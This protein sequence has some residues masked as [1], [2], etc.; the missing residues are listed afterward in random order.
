MLTKTTLLA[1]AAAATLSA[2]PTAQ[3]IG[4]DNLSNGQC[5]QQ[6]DL[7]VPQ[8]NDISLPGLGV[9]YDQCN[10][11]QQTCLGDVALSTPAQQV[12]G[13]YTT[14]IKVAD[15]SGNALLG[16]QGLLD[17]TR[18]WREAT[19]NGQTFQV[20]RFT[21][22]ADLSI[23]S[24][25]AINVCPVPSCLVAHPTA[26][27]Y[28][29]VDYALDCSNPGGGLFENAVVMYH[30][31]DE[32]IHRPGLSDRPGAFHPGR[33]FAI[34]APHTTANPFDPTALVPAPGGPTT[35]EAVR[36]TPALTGT[37]LC[38]TEEPIVQGQQLPLVSGC[39]CPLSVASQQ[40]TAVRMNGIGACGAAGAAGSAYQTLNFFPN[41]PWFD[42]VSTSLGRWTT[43]ASYPGAERVWVNEGL[44]LYD[45]SCLNAQGIPGT[46]LDMNYGSTTGSG[47][48]PFPT[49][50]NQAGITD[51]FT[52]LASNASYDL[53][54]PIT[55]PILGTMRKS[56]HLIYTNTP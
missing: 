15:C 37:A 3:C 12:C 52:D 14:D 11:T 51:R 8:W 53:T 32:F 43:M 30:A 29:Y 45:D 21:L 19:P 4:P 24:P 31:C 40:Q 54:Q 5:W 36:S 48:M 26:F 49:E 47:Y 28:G 27:F 20:W 13:M 39:L 22:K 9:C 41:L 56:T 6:V 10:P 38:I 55:L 1:A 18:T 50:N 7:T 16:G 46:Y 33:S 23:S 17:Y 2:L 42:M 25:N 35:A 44:F 34:V